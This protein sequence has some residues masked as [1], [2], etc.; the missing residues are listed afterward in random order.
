[1]FDQ[2]MESR[3]IAKRSTAQ[4]LVSIAAH[5]VVIAVSIQLTRAVAATAVNEP[6]A[7]EMRIFRTPDHVMP[8]TAAPT[9]AT[10]VST[11]PLMAV[12]AP[13]L[14]VPTNVPPIQVGKSFD[15]SQFDP[16]GL[17]RN[18]VPGM[19]N[20]VTAIDTGFVATLAQVDEPTVLLSAPLPVYPAAL[21]EVGIQGSVFLRYVVGTDSVV[22]K[23]SFV[24]VQSTNRA[25]EGPAIDAI[26]L[27]KFRPAKIKGKPVQQLVE[28][29]VRF[30]LKVN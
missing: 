12:P 4:M 21:K 24:V 6:I 3:P 18:L 9:T 7:T 20:D 16:K 27:A 17:S 2:L 29:V 28:Q 25:F 8:R 11:T 14:A 1:M 13:P 10:A 30:T 19:G 26:K 22:D 5:T 23:T 15:V